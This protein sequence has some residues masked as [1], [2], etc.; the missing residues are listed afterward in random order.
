[1]DY[2]LDARDKTSDGIIYRQFAGEVQM[3]KID[4]EWKIYSTQSKKIKEVKER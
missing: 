1:M 2:V 4:G 3:E